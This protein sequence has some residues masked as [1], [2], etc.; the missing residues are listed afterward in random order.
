MRFSLKKIKDFHEIPLYDDAN[1]GR[2]TNW[3][4]LNYEGWEKGKIRVSK[5]NKKGDAL[6]GMTPP[7]QN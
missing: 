7:N 4:F 3:N 1:A 6:R 5:G 2:K